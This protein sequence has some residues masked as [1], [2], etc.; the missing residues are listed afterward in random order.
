MK[1][2]YLQREKTEHGD[3]P[4]THQEYSTWYEAARQ[5][6]RLHC[7]HEITMQ[8]LIDQIYRDPEKPFFP[9][10]ENPHRKD[11]A[12]LWGSI[13]CHQISH[14]F[15]AFPNWNYFTV[16][17]PRLYINPINFLN[18]HVEYKRVAQLKDD[19]R[20][21]FCKPLEGTK[22]FEATCW[23][24]AELYESINKHSYN[25]VCAI[26]EPIDD[27]D[28]GEE[29][30]FIVHNGQIISG[31]SYITPEG[32][33]V[34][35]FEYHKWRQSSVDWNASTGVFARF[36]TFAKALK[37]YMPPTYGMDIIFDKRD[38]NWKLLEFNWF[39]SMGIYGNTITPILK[40][41]LQ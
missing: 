15:A 34:H 38:Q 18:H 8:G 41:L 36:N 24:L 12:F 9:I 25:T 17:Y 29:I 27:D 10:Q 21:M 30:R 40:D 32:K 31:A 13:E 19:T 6:A 33:I 39:W 20:T 26:S 16:S 5:L 7:I 2:I 3:Y 37:P 14:C 11:G 23:P 35:P 1:M 22:V 4:F 28:L